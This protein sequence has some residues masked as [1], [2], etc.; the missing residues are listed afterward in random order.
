MAGTNKG[1]HRTY[2][3]DHFG[4]SVELQERLQFDKLPDDKFFRPDLIPRNHYIATASWNKCNWFLLRGLDPLIIGNFQ[5]SWNVYGVYT[6]TY[7]S[8]NTRTVLS[9]AEVENVYTYGITNNEINIPLDFKTDDLT[10]N[11]FKSTRTVSA[12]LE[13]N[14]LHDKAVLFSDQ[15]D[16]LT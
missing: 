3:S 1:E 16:S 9:S 7:H 5:G 6:R 2:I 10:S 12:V 11:N 14:I 15:T 8:R 13:K 4:I